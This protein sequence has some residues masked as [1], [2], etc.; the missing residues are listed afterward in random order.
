MTSI[1]TDWATS[2][3]KWERSTMLQ[4][5][6]RGRSLSFKCFTAAIGTLIFYAYFHLSRLFR[7]IHQPQ[8]R[9]VYPFPFSI[10]KSPTYEITFFIQISGGFSTVLSNVSIDSFISIFLLH[11]CAQ[12][13]NLRMTINILVEELANKCISPSKFK[14]R[15]TA[16]VVRHE[17]L[18]RYVD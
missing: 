10:Q 5:A 15:L 6:K 1:T 3:S 14:E 13:I 11:T 4:I 18:I 8:R 17:I 7:N 12:L 2:K 16:I 9:L